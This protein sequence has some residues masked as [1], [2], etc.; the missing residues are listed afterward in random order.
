MYVVGLTGGIASGKTTVSQMLIALGAY[1][2]DADEIARA[3]VQPNQPA[4]Y[5]IKAH[6]GNEIVLPDGTINRMALGE[7]IFNDKEERRCL[8][9]ITHPY[10][11][12][13]INKGIARG[14]LLG[15]T[16][17]VLDVPLLFEIG[18]QDMV[19]AIWVVSVQQDVQIARLMARNDLSYVQAMA[20]I[21]SQMSLAEKIKQADVIIDN[22]VEIENVEKQVGIA[23]EKVCHR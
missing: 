21:N 15:Y 8:D 10:I 1:L 19:N 9:N 5:E 11:K 2:I 23:W 12:D 16:T 20:R 4:W 22:N 14:Q 18:W 3:I 7:K 6:F 13:E 17:I